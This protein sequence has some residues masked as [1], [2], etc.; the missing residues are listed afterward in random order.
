VDLL[1][2]LGREVIVCPTASARRSAA[3][4]YRWRKSSRKELPIVFNPNQYENA[5]I[6][7]ALP[8]TGRKSGGLGR[9]NHDFFAAWARWTISAWG[10]TEKEKNPDVKLSAS[11]DRI[12]VLRIRE[13]GENRQVKRMSWKASARTIFR[14][15]WIQGP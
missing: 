4:N 6:P 5:M 8:D 3:V 9:K 11:T 1:K 14:R 15:Q 2:A 10:V 12:A 13:D 7:G